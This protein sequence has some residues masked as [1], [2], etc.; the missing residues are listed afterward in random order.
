MMQETEQYTIGADVSCQ[1][2]HCGQLKRVVV[3]PVKRQLTHLVVDP[4]DGDTRLVP[5]ALTD[6]TGRAAGEAIRLHCTR[7]QLASLEPAQ[8]TQFLPGTGQDFGYAPDQLI[9]WPYY[10]LAMGGIGLGAPGLQALESQPQTVTYDRVP[11]SELEIRRGDRV[12][13][14]D[15]EIGHVQGLVV[16]PTDHGVTHVLLKEGH[17]WGRKTVAIPIRAVTPT[18]GDLHVRMS[19]AEL[20]DLPPVDLVTND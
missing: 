15:G 14:T 1:D 13:A 19:K 18:G 6:A 5:V 7:A 3:D 11:A 9:S 8:E 17:L 20:A 12:Q 16:D 2:G 10:P 4:T